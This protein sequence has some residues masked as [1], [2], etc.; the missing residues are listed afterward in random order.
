MLNSLTDRQRDDLRIR[1]WDP[2]QAYDRVDQLF[3]LLAAAT[4]EGWDAVVDGQPVHIDTDWV[5]DRVLAASLKDVPAW[6]SSVAVD[7]TDIE[8]WGRLHGQLDEA[9]LDGDHDDET[10]QATPGKSKRRV[11]PARRARILGV[12]S[13]GRN[14]YTKDPDAR[15]GHRSAT[16]SRDAGLY[17]GYELHM[18]VLARDA[19]W[20]KR[21]RSPQ[22]RG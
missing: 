15:A 5:P 22:P 18:A 4:D 6:S 7:G 3:N 20:S 12:D 14:I 17:V 21:H 19:G 1:N 9:D 10:D 8:T 11:N 13:D 2:D 16:S